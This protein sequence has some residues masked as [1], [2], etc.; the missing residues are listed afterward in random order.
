M[1]ED[2]GVSGLVAS[3]REVRK[4]GFIAT[5]LSHA[6]QVDTSRPRHSCRR[7]RDTLIQ[8][9]VCIQLQTCLLSHYVSY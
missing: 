4:K 1:F 7:V 3:A 2:W 8:S 6:L 9:I 5:T